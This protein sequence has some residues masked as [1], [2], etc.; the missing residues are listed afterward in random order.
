MGDE[1][2]ASG[3]A[4]Y[5]YQDGKH[6]QADWCLRAG[7]CS[8]AFSNGDSYVGH[9]SDARERQGQG[10]YTYAN[11]SEEEQGAAAIYDGNWSKGEKSGLGTFS[12]PNG[13][14]YEGMWANGK[15]N[16]QG[17][18]VYANGDVFSGTWSNDVKH[19]KGAYVF[20]SP[21]S[22]LVGSWEGGECVRGKWILPDMSSF[23][24][25]FAD[26]QPIGKGV[27]YLSNGLTQDGN[28]APEAK[29]D[30]E[31]DGEDARAPAPRS[32]VGG[33]ISNA[34]CD[35]SDLLVADASGSNNAVAEEEDFVV[36]AKRKPSS[37]ESKETEEPESVAQ[38]KSALELLFD[39]V[40]T[41]DDG[42]ITLTELCTAINSDEEGRYNALTEA[43]PNIG[44]LEFNQFFLDLDK[45]K[46]GKMNLDEFKE[47]FYLLKLFSA[48]DSDGSGKVRHRELFQCLKENPE[49]FPT[50]FGSSSASRVTISAFISTG[51]LD[52]DR[53]LDFPE[54]C[55]MIISLT[56]A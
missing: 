5:T 50:G 53:M 17:T 8:V 26:G 16:G 37:E 51:D 36:V 15:K 55:H 2:E 46:N 43:C 56:S 39:M 40:D 30:G 22:Q 14:K 42:G 31:D 49:L 33:K 24:G 32:Y 29:E 20:K 1:G 6:E 19:G 4:V 13:D 9:M 52:D 41:D 28:Y 21:K 11:K 48:V 3:T 35:V 47:Y 12:Y 44:S 7:V 54:F 34:F 23:H 45:D 38:E 18:F 25:Q 10:V 27:Y